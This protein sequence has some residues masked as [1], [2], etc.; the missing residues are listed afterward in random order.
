M[1]V[2]L[3][4]DI[5]ADLIICHPP[6]FNSYKYSSINSLELAW[7]DYDY[8]KISKEEVK[9]FFKVGK[10]ENAKFYVQDMVSV[11]NNLH[12]NIKKNGILALMIG[13]TI[14]HNNYISTNITC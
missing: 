5:K 1:R 7:L 4:E 12:N 6:Y 13:D 10:E 3:S 2:G 9:K 8:K 14:I 11:I